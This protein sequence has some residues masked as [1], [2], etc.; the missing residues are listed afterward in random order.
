[1]P[2]PS[3][4]TRRSRR[5][6]RWGAPIARTTARHRAPPMPWRASRPTRNPSDAPVS[7]KL[8][9]WR[10]RWVG[11]GLVGEG[12]WKA[13]RRER[14]AVS[15]R[16]TCCHTDMCVS[17]MIYEYITGLLLTLSTI[18]GACHSN[19]ILY[20]FLS[21]INTEAFQYNTY[22]PFSLSTCHYPSS[23]LLAWF[24]FLSH[25]A[26]TVF[27]QRQ[28][29]YTENK[30]KAIKARNEYLLALEATNGCVFK[31]YIH[32][33]SDIIDVSINTQ[34]YLWEQGAFVD[35]ILH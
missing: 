14:K 11:P 13:A 21:I 19:M 24:L 15:E 1:M 3:W 20:F 6:S 27:N 25:S 5:R 22:Y 7:K 16:P 26:I 10:R 4:R 34:F 2:S 12:K 9:R 28:A 35:I 31:Y 8:R 32:D 17:W 29:K 23:F 33:L 30:L 18:A